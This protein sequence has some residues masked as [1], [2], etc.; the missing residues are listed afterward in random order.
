MTRLFL[1]LLPLFLLFTVTDLDAGK[2]SRYPTPRLFADREAARYSSKY[3]S[4]YSSRYSTRSWKTDCYSCQ[5]DKSGRIARSS[6]ARTAFR[7]A[8]PCP[9]TGKT[10]SSCTGYV[11]DH[12]VPL[13]HG[14]RDHPS[15]MQW[16][17]REAA[18]AKD[19]ME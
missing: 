11:I 6:T 8:N 15:N 13:K 4:K 12:R 3:S 2:S 18:R 1:S 10:T 19:R 7:K 5:G 14:G 16:Q 9:S 17:T